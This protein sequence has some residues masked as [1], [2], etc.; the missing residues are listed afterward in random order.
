MYFLHAQG[1]LERLRA[2]TRYTST[3]RMSF[4]FVEKRVRGP[5]MVSLNLN[6]QFT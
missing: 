2:A 1:L 5:E 4:Q 3:T 6:K